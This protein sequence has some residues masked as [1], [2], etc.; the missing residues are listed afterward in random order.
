MSGISGK[1]VAIIIIVFVLI[2][3]IFGI[4]KISNAG[5]LRDLLPGFE[6]GE[7]PIIW[8]GEE[9]LL[10]PGFIAYKMVG[11]D[12]NIYFWYNNN[13]LVRGGIPQEEVIGWQWNKVKSYTFLESLNPFGDNIIKRKI[14]KR[15]EF[16][17][18]IS[19]GN[20]IRPEFKELNKKNKQT[21]RLLDEIQKTKKSPAEEGLEILVNRVRRNDE[22]NEWDDV[23]LDV[24]IGN[25]DKP[26]EIYEADDK[27]LSDLDGLII[28]FNQISR[29]DV[30]NRFGELE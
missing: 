19:V 4:A 22:S 1:I 11:D 16:I 15:A 18:W 30:K 6:K 7:Q 20:Q 3:A 14:F 17:G 5:T 29:G 12:A 23:T 10:Y 27:R 25:F 24:Y 13:P 9:K 8:S 21:I 28:K 26:I 2:I